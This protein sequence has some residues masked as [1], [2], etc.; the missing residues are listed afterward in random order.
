M[1][2]NE[3]FKFPIAKLNIKIIKKINMATYITIFLVELIS[4]YTLWFVLKRILRTTKFYRI[5]AICFV[6]SLVTGYIASY[7]YIGY[8]VTLDYLTK[9]NNQKI[10]LSGEG[11]TLE[12]QNAHK[13]DLVNRKE[14][15]Q[16]LAKNA[17]QLSLLPSILVMLIML[18]SVRKAIN[19]LPLKLT[20][21]SK[22]KD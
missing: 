18:L 5:M 3:K 10:E 17:F 9:I 12:E 14:F 8:E 1:G 7:R 13:E 2:R 21:P 20:K 15:K 19:N 11:I 22:K 16:Y 6:T 4:A